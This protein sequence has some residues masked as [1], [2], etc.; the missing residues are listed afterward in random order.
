MKIQLFEVFGPKVD[1]N[2]T[3]QVTQVNRETV[4]LERYKIQQLMTSEIA[5]RWLCVCVCHSHVSFSN[6]QFKRNNLLQTVLKTSI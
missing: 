2:F 1:L 6:D 4:K 3:L 5:G